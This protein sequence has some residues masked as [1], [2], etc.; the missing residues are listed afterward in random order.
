[1]SKFVQFSCFILKLLFLLVDFAMH[2]MSIYVLYESI[3][4]GDIEVLPHNV[5]VCTCLHG[6]TATSQG[7]K[8][9]EVMR[10]NIE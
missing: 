5:I 10:N 1:M 6:Q 7:Q 4:N 2:G 9:T 3:I 8:L